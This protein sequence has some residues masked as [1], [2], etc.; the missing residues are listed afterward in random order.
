MINNINDLIKASER[1]S[2][3]DDKIELKEKGRLEFISKFPLASIQNFKI[4]DY[5]LGTSEKSF[6]YWLEFKGILFGIGGGNASKFGIYK[7]KDGNYYEGYGTK[8][9]SLQANILDAK[10]LELKKAIIKGLD[11][12]RKNEIEKIT[13]IQTSI[14]NIVLL[15]IF[16]LYYPEKF[17]TIGDPDVIIECAKNIGIKGVELKNENSIFINYLCRKKLNETKEFSNWHYEKVG[18]LIWQ[19]FKETAKRDYYLIGSK[20]GKNA[21]KDVFPEML[22]KSVVATGFAS[23]IDL[24]ELYNES[25]S[26]IKEFLQ[27]HNEESNSI[28]AIKHFLTLRPG[29]LVAIKGDGSP[30]GTEGYLSIVGIAEVIE[31]NGK[32]YEYDPKGLGHIIN[33]KFINAPIFKEL[34]LGG[35]GRTIHKLSNEEHIKLIFKSNNEMRYFEEL[36]KFLGQAKTDDL[37]TIRNNY[38]Q[39]YRGLEIKISFGQGGAAKIPWIS[40]LC[41]GQTTSNGIYPVYLYFKAEN[42]LI[43]AYGVSVTNIPNKKWELKDPKT[44]SEYFIENNLGSPFN[45]GNSFIFKTYS[46]ND[47]PTSSTIDNDLNEILNYYISLNLM[48]DAIPKI[49][50]MNLDYR[51]FLEKSKEAG[52]IFSPQLIQRLIASLCTKPFVICSGLSGSG[53]TK[54]AQAFAQWITSDESQYVIVPVGAD[55]TN[56]EPLLGYPNALN[57][58]EYVSPENGVLD[59]MIRAKLNIENT[60]EPTKP[61]FLILDEM[62]LSHVE[63]YFADFLS[64]MESGDKIPL[65]RIIPEQGKDPIYIP[66]SINLPKNLFIIGTVNIDETTYMFS[67]KVLD[68]ANTIEFRLTENDLADFIKSDVKLDMNL[69]KTQGSNMSESFIQMV[70]PK[71]EEDDVKLK[72]EKDILKSS[73]ADLI[74]FFLELKKSGAE[75]GF[76]TVSEIG[77][78]L[79]ML[80]ELGESGDNLLDIAI[81]QKLLPKLHGSRNKLS[82]VLPIL[83]GFCLTDNSKIKE[84]YLDK[85]LS[86][87]L[88]EVELKDDTN[89]K[90]KISF[91]KICRMYKNAVENGFASYAEA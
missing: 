24:T 67:P 32:V 33:V 71:K 6:S 1:F 22:K 30:K 14:W 85:F 12:V 23:K 78:L 13:T 17:L 59:L 69:L 54:L 16:C 82:K 19:T 46:I 79:Y 39:K 63:R 2:M 49:S 64:T 26:E 58:E 43:L 5:C 57:K 42:L 83:G 20:Y 50:K 61:Y 51:T 62:N 60:E 53:K 40:F 41:K 38:L 52:L 84:D 56:R 29:D 35:Y 45:Y 28:N 91:E 21:D 74:L 47:L 90:Y 73:E 4:N 80:K 87:S 8:K 27:L 68:R 44:I 10:F 86:N 31:K 88:T 9:T 18:T 11:F 55:W 81:M 77:R 89:I 76:R 34:S 75:F 3:P 48:E 65:H 15:K 72:E 36:N 7:S 25:H 66:Q 70:I 37:G